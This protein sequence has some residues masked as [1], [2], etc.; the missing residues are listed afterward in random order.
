MQKVDDLKAK[1]TVS[2]AHNMKNILAITRF[3]GG[4]FVIPVAEKL[5][6]TPLG[7]LPSEAQAC[8]KV[9]EG[10]RHDKPCSTT[11]L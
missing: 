3:R 6:A 2:C 9:S 5:F 4:A 7:I 1:R 10:H 11:V 8:S